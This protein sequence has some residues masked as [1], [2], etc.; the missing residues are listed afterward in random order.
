[1]YLKFRFF[2]NI[3]LLTEYHSEQIGVIFGIFI[4]VIKI[5]KRE[6]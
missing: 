5:I 6:T 1:M 2:L 4:L 3:F